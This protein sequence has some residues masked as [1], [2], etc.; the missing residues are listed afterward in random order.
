ASMARDGISGLT[1]KA[2]EGTSVVHRHLADALGRGRAAGLPVLGAYHVVR[3]GSVADQVRF[4]LTYLDAQIPW[5]RTQPRF[6]L[7]VDGEKWS[8]DQVSAV[9]I[10]A[11]TAALRA[12]EP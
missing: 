3:S 9:Q 12:A 8:Y 2:T 11:F 10:E 7:Q 4:F 1:H 5:W 6:F